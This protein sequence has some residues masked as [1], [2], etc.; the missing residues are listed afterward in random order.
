[1]S[2]PPPPSSRIP[3]SMPSTSTSPVN[4]YSVFTTPTESVT[5]QL[6]PNIESSM[7]PLDF[8]MNFPETLDAASCSS[9]IAASH[10]WSSP[11]TTAGTSMCPRCA[12]CF[13]VSELHVDSPSP[14]NHVAHSPTWR[15]NG[16]FGDGGESV[17]NLRDPFAIQ[18][19]RPSTFG[20]PLPAIQQQ[21]NSTR[22]ISMSSC[23]HCQHH[24]PRTEIPPSF[25]RPGHMPLHTNSD[26]SMACQYQP[27]SF[28]FPSLPTTSLNGQPHQEFV[29]VPVSE[30]YPPSSRNSGYPY[31]LMYPSLR[32]R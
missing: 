11:C 23:S 22:P 16:T 10:D 21:F 29:L 5:S 20:S 6:D 12:S 24:R 8:P 18:V 13:G 9:Q 14:C 31:D 15:D 4:Q 30:L 1:M 7:E 3:R 26:M 28:N 2:S 17:A 25:Q 19:H 32:Y 27:T